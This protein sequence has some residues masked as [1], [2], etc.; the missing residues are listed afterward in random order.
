MDTVTIDRLPIGSI[1]RLVGGPGCRFLKITE[2]MIRI[3]GHRRS[4]TLTKWLARQ[5]CVSL[6]HIDEAMQAMDE[7][8]REAG[9]E[10]DYGTVPGPAWT[11]WEGSRGGVPCDANALDMVKIL[12]RDG[13]EVG[14]KPAHLWRWSWTGDGG[15][16][17]GYRVTEKADPPERLYTATE[18]K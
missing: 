1:A 7:V 4:T 13:D 11:K 10:P 5:E 6:G 3:E 16:I 12:R 18:A 14:P 2:R 17:V 8:A 9:G 15:D